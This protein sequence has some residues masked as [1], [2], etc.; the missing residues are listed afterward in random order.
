MRSAESFSCLF[1][2]LNKII[3]GPKS[4]A[5]EVHRNFVIDFNES[6]MWPLVANPEWKKTDIY[7]RRM[8]MFAAQ[9]PKRVSE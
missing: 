2:F 9:S 5:I 7:R 6:K 3:L 1:F 4:L 8:S